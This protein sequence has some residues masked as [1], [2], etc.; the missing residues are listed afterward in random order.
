MEFEGSDIIV[1]NYKE[2]EYL[3]S[4]PRV[5]NDLLYNSAISEHIQLEFVSL[6]FMFCMILFR[7][8]ANQNFALFEVYQ[9]SA[10]N[11]ELVSH[12]SSDI[13]VFKELKR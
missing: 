5:G 11:L 10:G 9:W 13:L 7:E 12:I 6:L 3:F 4:A 8:F 2:L 1:F